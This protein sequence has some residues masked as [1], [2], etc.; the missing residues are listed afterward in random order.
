[1]RQSRIAC[2]G[3]LV[4]RDATTLSPMVRAATWLL[5]WVPG[6]LGLSLRW[7]ASPTLRRALEKYG[8]SPMAV[9]AGGRG[10]GVSLVVPADTPHLAQ[11]I[12][13]VY[14]RGVLTQLRRKMSTGE[15]VV[16]IGAQTPSSASQ[17]QPTAI[18]GL[19]NVA[20]GHTQPGQCQRE[21][22]LPHSAA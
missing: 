10:S 19:L 4:S 16:D 11:W 7:R 6:R 15:N 1:M 17:L 5:L 22:H 14:E 8:D 18:V 3:R 20:L 12:L 2:Y 13:D 9:R 21:P